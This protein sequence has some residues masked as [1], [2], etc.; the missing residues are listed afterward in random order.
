MFF[1]TLCFFVEFLLNKFKLFLWKKKDG[2]P[3]ESAHTCGR[4]SYSTPRTQQSIEETSTPNIGRG[5]ET[6][7]KTTVHSLATTVRT[8]QSITGVQA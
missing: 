5:A 8:L 1:L 3:Q 4:F 6:Q 2:K 7:P